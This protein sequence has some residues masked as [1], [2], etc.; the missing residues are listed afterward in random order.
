MAGRW[1][2]L[3]RKGSGMQGMTRKNAVGNQLLACAAVLLAAAALFN[4]NTWEVYP[5]N[6]AILFRWLCM[7]HYLFRSVTC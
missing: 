2:V 6:V 3:G 5:F 1:T 7:L 4:S